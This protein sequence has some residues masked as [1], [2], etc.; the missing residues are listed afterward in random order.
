MITQVQKQQESAKLAAPAPGEAAAEGIASAVLQFRFFTTLWA[1]ASLF[2]MAHSSVFDRQLNLALL[3]IAAFFAIFRPSLTSFLPLVILQIFDAVFRMPM[4]TNHWIFTAFANGTILHALFFLIVKNRSLRVGEGQL[5]KTFA[6]LVRIEVIVLYFFAVFH[7]LNSGF[8]TPSASCATDLLIAQNVAAVIPLNENIF[9][10]NAYFTLLVELSIPILLCFRQ[11]RNAGVLVGLIF[12]CILS[13]STYNAFY[14]FSSVMFA[15]YFLFL[16]PAFSLNT[17]KT[18]RRIKEQA[19]NWLR[20][21]SVRKLAYITGMAFLLLV[22]LVI[23]NKP[24]DSS[25]RVHLY[26]FWTVYSLMFATVIIMHIKKRNAAVTEPKRSLFVAPHWSLLIIPVVVFLNGTM[27]YLGLKTE[28]S[29]AMFSNL[30][31]E[32]GK[33]NHFLVPASVQIFHYQKDVV[34]IVSS[35]DTFL[36]KLAEQNKALVLFDFRNYVQEHKPEVV[37]YLVNGERKIFTRGDTASMRELGTNPYVL[38]K[39]MKF[40][41][42]ALDGPQ[43][44]AH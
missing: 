4:T 7:K 24:L 36:Q 38:R 5:F 39:L 12:H 40:R 1:V 35:T 17:L 29:Y 21:Y 26:F 18:A 42:F 16:T 11:T 15:V 14:D 25:Y 9:L 13:Y 34:Q 8:F 23:V 37:E 19:M 28:N 43:P 20:T 30:R 22:A 33:T 2:H 32:G 31:T 6:P 41:P 44:C 27:P 3:T 10:L